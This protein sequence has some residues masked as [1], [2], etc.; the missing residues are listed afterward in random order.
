[1]D[2]AEFS[3]LLTEL[4]TSYPQVRALRVLQAGGGGEAGA[5]TRPLFSSA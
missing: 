2:S 3:R 1:V 5:Y 4:E